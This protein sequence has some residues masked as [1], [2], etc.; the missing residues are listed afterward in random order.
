MLPFLIWEEYGSS[1]L[2]LANRLRTYN[3]A[4]FIGRTAGLAALVILIVWMDTKL[5]GAIAGSRLRAGYP[6]IDRSLRAFFNDPFETLFQR[7]RG[8]G[9]AWRFRQAAPQYDWG[10]FLLAQSTILMLSHLATQEEVGWYSLAYQTVSVLLII[11]QSATLV[12]YSRMAA[13]GPN[14]IWP[15][16]KKI[17]IRVMAF[18]T[19]LSAAAVLRG[20]RGRAPGR[21]RVHPVRRSVPPS[22]SRPAGHVPGATHDQSVD[23]SRFFPIDDDPDPG[24]SFAEYPFKLFPD[25]SIRR[26]RRR[27]VHACRLCGAGRDGP[28]G[29][30]VLVRKGMEEGDSTVN[31]K[32]I[33]VRIAGKPK[34][35]SIFIL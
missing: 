24:N 10:S 6:R 21:G 25:P 30:C 7:F 20:T 11:P 22:S 33:H 5:I 26:K 18:L 35:M 34:R 32:S 17:V 23:R 12:L 3:A 28:T 14:G 27:V 1:L 9:P 29:F 19:V 31:E 4:Q 16:Q 13:A 15:E 2:V 8:K